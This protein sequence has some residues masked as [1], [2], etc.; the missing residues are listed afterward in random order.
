LPSS[1]Y[2]AAAPEEPSD[3]NQIYELE[4]KLKTFGILDDDEI[5]RFAAILYKGPLDPSDRIRLEGLV[6]Q[7]VQRFEVEDDE[8]RKEEFRQLLKSYIRFYSF[9]AHVV[10]L[11][12]T[13]REKLYSYAAWLIRLL[14]NCGHLDHRRDDATARLQDRAEGGWQRLTRGGR[15]HAAVADQGVCR[16]TIHGRGGKIA[17]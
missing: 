6:R 5:E 10:S 11:G 2:E 12:D 8:G 16:K 3:P 14:P 7:A 1:H 4:S 17:F 9:V 13:G 15:Y